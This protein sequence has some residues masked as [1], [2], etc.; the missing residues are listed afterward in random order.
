MKFKALFRS[1]GRYRRPARSRS[2]WT[3]EDWEAE[4][5]AERAKKALR[6]QEEALDE[7][8]DNW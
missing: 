3:K 6:D 5:A 4:A 8:E 7:V 2:K 1:K